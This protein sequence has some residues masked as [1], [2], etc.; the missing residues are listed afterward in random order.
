M[1]FFDASIFPIRDFR[2]SLVIHILFAFIE[3]SP[4]CSDSTFFNRL[5]YAPFANTVSHIES[6]GIIFY[7]EFAARARADSSTLWGAAN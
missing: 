6:T 7:I 4:N 2:L 3:R 5:Q 1:H